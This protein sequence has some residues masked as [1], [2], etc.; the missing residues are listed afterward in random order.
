MNKTQLKFLLNSIGNIHRNSDEANIFLFATARSGSTWL[1]ELIAG[2]PGFKF[3]DEPLNIRR[4]NVQH[5][6]LFSDWNTLM[7]EAQSKDYIFRYLRA[8]AHNQYKH[9]NPT[10]FRKNYRLFTNRIIFKIHEIE[11]LIEDVQKKFGGQILYL[12]RHPIATTIS[13]KV[14]PRINCFI[15]SNYFMNTCLSHTQRNE[16]REVYNKGTEYDRGI[17]SWC[18]Q[19]AIPL[20]HLNPRNWLLITYE[21]LVLNPA[22]SCNLLSRHFNLPDL[23]KMLADIDAPSTNIKMSGKDTLQLMEDQNRVRRQQGL[24]RKWRNKVSAAQEA[25]TY[26]IMA[27]FD[28]DV[29]TR[30]SFVANSTY[31]HFDDTAQLAEESS[32]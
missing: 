8:L 31:L 18:F 30:G 27:M 28:M 7:P 1:M 14:L 11:H 4:A 12:L 23:K 29:Y 22:K 6:G 13:R 10:P 21:E 3:F 20:Y 9:M 5:T 19:H 26:E 17:L 24:V 2:Q 15:S 32:V 25:R 16:V